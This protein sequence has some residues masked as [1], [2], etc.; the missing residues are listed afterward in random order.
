MGDIKLCDIFNK[1]SI[2]IRAKEHWDFKSEES[3]LKSGNKYNHI[4]IEKNI[5]MCDWKNLFDFLSKYG[6]PHVKR[7]KKI[8][9]I[10]LTKTRTR[11]RFIKVSNSIT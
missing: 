11:Y 2:N 9:G 5:S 1:K 7:S 6:K 8:I 10:V 3:R 4:F